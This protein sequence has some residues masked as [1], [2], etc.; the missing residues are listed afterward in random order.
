MVEN[1]LWRAAKVLVPVFLAEVGD[2]TM[3]ATAALSMRTNP[4]VALAISTLAYLTANALPVLLA[5]KAAEVLTSYADVIQVSAGM[6]FVAVGFLLALCGE[7]DRRR[8]HGASSTFSYFLL[9]TLSEMGDKTQ[10][11]TVLSAA[12]TA[13][14]MLTLSLGALSYVLANS[15]GV[16]AA[17]LARNRLPAEALRRVSAALFVVIGV[18]CVLNAVI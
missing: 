15:I 14:F 8:T 10:V 16:A 12:L 17:Q 5:S 9:L 3:L 11:V 4:V 1:L 6:G 2:K 7:R 18:L 13:N